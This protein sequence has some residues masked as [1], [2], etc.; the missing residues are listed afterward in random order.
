MKPK[1]MIRVVLCTLLAAVLLP[2]GAMAGRNPKIDAADLDIA[3][4]I[5]DVSADG[6]ANVYH[7]WTAGGEKQAIE[8]IINGFT[9]IYTNIEA[10]S[11]AIPGGAGGAM[12]MKVKVLQQAGKSPETFQA[13][14]GE[15]IEPY[16]ASD[17]LLDLSQ[18][19]EY[20]NLYDRVLP[21]LEEFCT[22]ADDL[23]HIVPIGIHKTNVIFYNIHVFEQYGIAIPDSQTITW[24]EFWALCDQLQAA[25]PNGYYPIDLGDRKGWPACQVFEDIM[26][27][28]DPQIYEDFINGN[29]TEEQVQTVLTTYKKLLSYVAPDHASRD[30]YE[31]SGQ[32]IAGSYAMQIMGAWMQPLMTS[33][34][35]VYGKDYGVLTFPGTD[36]WFGLCVDGFVVSNDS[37]D[38]EAGIRWAYNVTTTPVQ[39]AFST[40]KESISP[41]ADT[42]DET[43]CEL[44]LLFKEELVDTN[45]KTYPSFTHGTALPW[46]ASTDL[47]TR[48]QDFAVAS[49]P[50]VE[51]YAHNI[52]VA[53]RES[54]LEGDWDL[55]E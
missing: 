14:P 20:A 30:W 11:N 43:Y 26:M 16:L 17:M 48:I 7:W 47:Q 50:D 40:L 29:A 31:T 2:A 38:V 10:K 22:A 12:V 46:S 21:G 45:M 28:T 36:G 37:S 24:D 39:E 15:E 9:D 32:V 1:Q 41:Y 53:L 13:H 55:D 19:W 25:M 34:G 18:I 23:Q 44:T 27:G 52:V 4:I 3:S 6:T 42:P 51:R 8:S 35:Q 54:G 5:E 33:M 49:D